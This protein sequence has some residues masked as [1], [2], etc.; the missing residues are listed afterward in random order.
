MDRDFNYKVVCLAC[1][2]ARTTAWP[3]PP[4]LHAVHDVS[5]ALLRSLSLVQSLSLCVCVRACV[6]AC[7]CV[8][9]CACVRVR[10]YISAYC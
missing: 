7:V 6:R 9:V 2:T 3:L 1:T 8:C 4:V 5:L 10:V